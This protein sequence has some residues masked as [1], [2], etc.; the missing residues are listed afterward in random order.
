MSS[1]HQ[2]LWKLEKSVTA[3]LKV[4]REEEV[5]E[6]VKPEFYYQVKISLKNESE[7]KIFSDKE[8]LR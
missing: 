6:T 2:K 1:F 4:F 3:R 8:K 5:E 7:V